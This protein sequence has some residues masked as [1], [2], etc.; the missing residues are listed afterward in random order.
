[1]IFRRAACSMSLV[2]FQNIDLFD[3]PVDETVD[4][5]FANQLV[6]L[7]IALALVEAWCCHPALGVRAFASLR[8]LQ[9]LDAWDIEVVALLPPLIACAC[10]R[11]GV[12]AS[13]PT[14]YPELVRE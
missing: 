5:Q 14:S 11:D 3:P 9:R 6:S 2:L 1:M 7:P 4:S 8:S 12:A 10:A 13:D